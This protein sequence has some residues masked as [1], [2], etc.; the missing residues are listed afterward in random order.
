MK[1]SLWCNHV[2]LKDADAGNLSCVICRSS[3]AE[4][5]QDPQVKLA[6]GFAK[7]ESAVVGGKPNSK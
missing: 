4:G 6:W 5:A 2:W 3:K 1:I 7:E